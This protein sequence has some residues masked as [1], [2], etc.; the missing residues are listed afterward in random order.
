M[1]VDH[2][3]ASYRSRAIRYAYRWPVLTA[4]LTQVNFWI[5]A[6]TVLVCVNQL[7]VRAAA[8]TYGN[9][10]VPPPFFM[11]WVMGT[12]TAIV[13]GCTLGLIDLWMD[14]RFGPTMSVGRRILIKALLYTGAFA[15]IS[16]FTVLGFDY[17]VAKD[18]AGAPGPEHD[19]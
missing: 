18:S 14:R 15:I 10:M 2:S 3:P 17:L 1:P 8:L 11:V 7:V 9:D 19:R 6:N 12:L 13:Y 16:T 4:L 5:V